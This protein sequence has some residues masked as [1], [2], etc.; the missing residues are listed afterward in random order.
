MSIPHIKELSKTRYRTVAVAGKGISLPTLKHSKA[1]AVIACNEAIYYAASLPQFT[2]Y[3][4]SRCDFGPDIHICKN[5]PLLAIPILPKH[6]PT[7]V[8]TYHFWYTWSD[9]GLDDLNCTA[10]LSICIADY[11]GAEVI[12]LHGMDLLETGDH[13]YHE[14]SENERNKRFV[15]QSQE[16][17]M[18]RIPIEIRAKCVFASGKRLV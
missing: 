7:H 9:I 14:P 2:S 11:L 17:Q 13:R 1:E 15:L 6:A 16:K 3:F 12:E 8:Y 18:A 5:L 4:F 10:A